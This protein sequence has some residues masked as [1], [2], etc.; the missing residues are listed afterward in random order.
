[1]AR[2]LI[3]DDEN[4]IRTMLRLALAHVGHAAET[5]ADGFEGLERFGPDGAGWDLVLLD[6]RMPGMEGLEVLREMRRRNPSILV[7][8]ITAFGTIDLA[9]EAMQAGATN[10]LRKPFTVETLRAA[11]QAALAPDKAGRA[12]VRS[13]ASPTP[14]TFDQAN[15]NGYR[16]ASQPGVTETREHEIEDRFTVSSATGEERA[17]RVVLPAYLVELVKAHADRDQLP[18]GDAFW[19]ALCG[20]ALANHLWQHADLPEGDALRIEDLTRGLRHWIDAV[21]QAAER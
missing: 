17:C 4:N 11:V 10:F 18:G 19:Q 21:L 16:I 7:L 13:D 8:L 14:T 6:Q 9:D 5:A 2:I 3:I 20:E 1:M 12:L 15:I